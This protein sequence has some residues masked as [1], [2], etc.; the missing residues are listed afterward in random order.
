MRKVTVLF[1][2]GDPSSDSLYADTWEYDS[3]AGWRCIR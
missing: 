3:A 2:D 1:G